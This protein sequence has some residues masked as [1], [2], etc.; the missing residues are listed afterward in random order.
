MRRERSKNHKSSLL[1]R[2]KCGSLDPPESLGMAPQEV[3]GPYFGETLHQM[4]TVPTG[5]VSWCHCCCCCCCSPPLIAAVLLSDLGPKPS[6]EESAALKHSVLML[7]RTL[8][9]GFF[10]FF[11]FFFFFW[12]GGGQKRGWMGGK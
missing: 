2:E 9:A 12:G 10:F 8:V 4:F 11:L 7:H 1:K 3:P 6:E 5:D